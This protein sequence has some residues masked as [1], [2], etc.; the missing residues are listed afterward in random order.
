MPKQ[1]QP[2]QAHVQVKDESKS[3]AEKNHEELT[4]MT[5]HKAGEP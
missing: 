3:S 2:A 5:V 1:E 4:R